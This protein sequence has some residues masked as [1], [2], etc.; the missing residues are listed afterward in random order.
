MLSANRIKYIKSLHQKKYRQKYSQFLVEGLKAVQE[1]INQ[2]WH[3]DAIYVQQGADL[4]IINSEPFNTTYLSNAQMQR[5]STLKTAPQVL[6]VVQMNESQ[7]I[8]IGQSLVALDNINDPGNLGTIIRIADWYG[9]NQIL[10]SQTTVDEYNAKVVSATMGSL[11]R[12]KVVRGK[13]EHYLQNYDY[14]IYTALLDKG[15]VYDLKKVIPQFCLIIGNESH[16]ISEELLEEID[17]KPISI[18]KIGGAESLN[19]GVAAGILIDRLVNG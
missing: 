11:A 4:S 5:L 19:A 17:H 18:P 8:E 1:F 2:K 3:I 13:L 14:P 15:S 7:T 16:G 6:A 9:I 10:L 12:V